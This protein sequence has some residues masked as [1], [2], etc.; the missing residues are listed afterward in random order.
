MGNTATDDR[1]CSVCDKVFT[2]RNKR[3]IHEL[4]IHGITRCAKKVRRQISCDECP[5]TFQNLPEYRAHK[6]EKHEIGMDWLKFKYL[7]VC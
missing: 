7:I 6:S 4:D 1:T 2:R 5:L 3:K